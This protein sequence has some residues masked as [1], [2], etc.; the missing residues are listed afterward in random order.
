M[1]RCDWEVVETQL[2]ELRVLAD[3][4]AKTLGNPFV[5]LFCPGVSASEQKLIA[6]AYATNFIPRFILEQPDPSLAVKHDTGRRLRVGYLSA[7]YRN[8]PVG[9]V[10]P[11][12]VELHDR[13]RFEVIAFSVGVNDGS[14]IRSRLES[15]FDRFVDARNLSVHA[16]AECVRENNIDILIDLNGWTSDGRPETFAL[17]CAPIQV[18]WLG[19]AGTMGHPKL[20]DYLI[21]D[22]VV[23]PFDHA[24]CYTETL[25]LLPH[26]YLPVD[27]AQISRAAPARS[28]AGLPED[29]FVFCSFNNSYK[30]NPQVFDLWCKILRDAPNSCLWLSRP[31]GDA[32]DRLV[33]E[34]VSRGVAAD[35]I[36]FAPRVDGR[37]DHLL[38]LQLAD[39]ALD[40]FPYNSHSTGVDVLWAGVPMIS[41]LGET[42]PSRVGASL[43]HAVGLG[44]M[45]VNSVEDYHMVAVAMYRDRQRLADIRQR[46]REERDRQPLFDM[47][48]FVKSLECLYV[49]MYKNHSLGVQEAIDGRLLQK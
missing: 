1:R 45:V 24:D 3:G 15:A 8:H 28:E 46:L 7:D 38:R 27:T 41:C 13:S 22:P 36:I 20:A 4:Y 19:Y 21:G 48:E 39:I 9:F 30:F 18:N 44:E 17:R 35:R 40:P 5:S 12:V 11:K 29:V 2:S 16:L 37:E 6:S 42:F 33:A 10:F 26:C 31:A 43:L 32:A 25:A 47:P 49:E 34:A 14:E 23:T